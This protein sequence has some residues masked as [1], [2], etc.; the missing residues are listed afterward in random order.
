MSF[1]SMDTVK[2]RFSILQTRSQYLF[3]LEKYQYIHKKNAHQLYLSQTRTRSTLVRLRIFSYISINFIKVWLFI[4]IMYFKTKYCA[5]LC[6]FLTLCVF[7]SSNTI[8]TIRPIPRLSLYWSWASFRLLY[9][10][11]NTFYVHK[12][13]TTHPP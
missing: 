10:D 4:Y 13:R 11:I 6:N 12:I 9:G 5:V 7:I 1:A 2:Q 3:S 8:K